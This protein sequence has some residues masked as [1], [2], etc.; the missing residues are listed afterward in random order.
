MSQLEGVQEAVRRL[1][2]G[3][4][5]AIP[6]ETVY[7][8]AASVQYPDALASIYTL[9]G[10]PKDNPM[11][12]HGVSVEQ[13]LPFVEGWSKAHQACADAFWPGPLTLILRASQ[14]VPSFVTAGLD[15]VAIRIPNHPMA[16]EILEHVGPLAAPSANLSGSPSATKAS[17]VLDD[18][19]D[20]VAVVDG[21][22]A[23]IGL[24]STVVWAVDSPWRI[25]RP[26][27]VGAEEI[28][29]AANV[30]V[31]PTPSHHV[32]AQPVE[33]DQTPLSPGTKYRHYTPMARVM[34]FDLSQ[35]EA[36][37]IDPGKPRLFVVTHTD[38]RRIQ[39]KTLTHKHP[40]ILHQH[41]G[42]L[43]MLAKHLYKWYREADQHNTD[44]I[45]IEGFEA[46]TSLAISLHNRI[47]KTI[48]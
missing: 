18:F 47:S 44:I 45:F 29:H 20:A 34:W 16:L 30:M 23:A 37:S 10:R 43:D 2:D 4:V 8:L 42:S 6:T 38:E 12:L 48:G 35:I 22:Q 31:N 36:T 24:E 14:R 32:P 39:I 17:H 26:G 46:T 27:V 11:I 9:K 40:F 5:V 19:G 15:T 28:G 25:L 33:A 41:A 13:L 1:R 21:D 7:G 3:E